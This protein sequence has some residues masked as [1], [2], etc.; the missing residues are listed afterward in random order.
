MA[1][2][3]KIIEAFGLKTRTWTFSDHYGYGCAECCNGDRCDEDCDAKYKGR[4][5]DCPHCRG[6]G[7]IKLE[8]VTSGHTL[9]IKAINLK[10][11]DKVHYQPEHYD[12]DQYEVGIIKSIPEG[13]TD[14]VRVVYHCAGNWDNYMDYTS[15]LTNVRDLH[16]GWP[17]D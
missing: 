11:G 2:T 14:S 13:S 10:V 1:N 16:L 4:R 6:K 3:Y 17:T 12:P 7:F 15:A 8:D 5:K 9:P